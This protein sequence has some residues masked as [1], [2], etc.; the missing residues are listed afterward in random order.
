MNFQTMIFVQ[1]LLQYS[2]FYLIVTYKSRV[3]KTYILSVVE[4]TAFEQAF[5][6]S[7]SV[8]FL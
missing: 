3:Y 5:D 8:T 1:I 4:T 7:S 2:M 6:I